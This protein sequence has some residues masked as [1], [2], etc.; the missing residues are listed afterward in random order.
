MIGDADAGFAAAFAAFHFVLKL[1]H[2]ELDFA[3]DFA[4]FLRHF[5]LQ[6]SRRGEAVLTVAAGRVAVGHQ[7]RR[8]VA[9][10]TFQGGQRSVVFFHRLTV[11]VARVFGVSLGLKNIPLGGRNRLDRFRAPF[12]FVKRIT[13]HFFWQLVCVDVS[14]ISKEEIR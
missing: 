13:E 1:H 8:V 14:W 10:E 7:R 3:E 6:E 9:E 2:F 4:L 11:D 5:L 12:F